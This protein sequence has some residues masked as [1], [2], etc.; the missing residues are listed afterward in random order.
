MAENVPQIISAS[1]LISLAY[2][3][4]DQSDAAFDPREGCCQHITHDDESFLI[5]ANEL[6]FN[7][8]SRAPSNSEFYEDS[9]GISALS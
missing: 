4:V 5:Q 7:V 9:R 6:P 2:C 8:R 1:V 3:E